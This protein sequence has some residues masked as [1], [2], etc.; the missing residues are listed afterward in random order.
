MTMHTGI[1]VQSLLIFFDKAKS[2]AFV[3]IM[4]IYDYII[5]PSMNNAEDIIST[6]RPSSELKNKCMIQLLRI[7]SH[8]FN[9]AFS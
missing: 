6:D 5:N 1:I 8:K 7:L 9:K 3:C 4:Y 2:T